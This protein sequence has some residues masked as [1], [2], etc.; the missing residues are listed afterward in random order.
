M[1][2]YRVTLTPEERAGLEQLASVGKTA[3]RRITHARILLLA[4]TRA[5]GETDEAIVEAL[6][7]SSRTVARVRQQFVT[8]GLEVA[9]SRR[10]QPARPDKNRHSKIID[11]FID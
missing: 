7:C 9:V 11:S 2:K 1:E 8:C 4:D 6:G 10:A 3:A 5:G